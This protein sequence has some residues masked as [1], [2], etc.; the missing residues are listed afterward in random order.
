VRKLAVGL[1]LTALLVPSAASAAVPKRKGGKV[2]RAWPAKGKRD[3]PDGRLA[4]FLARQVGPVTVPQRVR[5]AQATS[6]PGA[7][8]DASGSTRLYLVRSYDIPPNDPSATRLANLS[9]TYDSA[10]SAVAL[11]STGDTS[12]ARQLLDQLAALQRT[13]GSLDFAYDT[14]TGA[15]VQLFRTGTIAWV[16]YAAL[17]QKISTGTA[18]YDSLI[19]GT[20]RWLLARRQPS[21]L[22]A[23]GPDVTW[24]STQNNLVA[25]QFLALL[26]L[27]PVG[28]LTT[29]QLAAAANG[30]ASGIDGTL[31]VTP[32]N[33]QLGFIQGTNDQLRP[34][35][36]QTLG[37]SYLLS[38]GRYVEALQVRTYI[39]S[40]FK[41]TGRSIVKSSATSTYNQTYSAAGPF[42]GYR[43]YATGGPDVLWF[44]GSAQANFVTGLLGIPHVMEDKA[45]A[46][47][48]NVTISRGEGPLQADRTVTNSTIN[49]YHVWPAS[50]AAGWALIST[51]GL[52]D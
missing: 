13:D 31:T 23:G 28:G 15:S 26:A 32:A 48:R 21:G 51:E 50:A 52:P 44:E 43:P 7:K 20:A 34:L 8:L 22:L 29:T 4:Q 11:E 1:T 47:F 45:L 49:E 27:T 25:Y 24:A 12:Q 42:S 33:G 16:G 2:E 17:L 9:W 6:V 40:A 41:V 14:S 19:N 46:A 35:D 5:A 30:I 3:K 39:E 36:A 10:I 37:I 38:R 18:R